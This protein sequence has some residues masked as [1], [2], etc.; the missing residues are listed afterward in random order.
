LFVGRE[1]SGRSDDAA[2]GHVH[3]QIFAKSAS[4]EFVNGAPQAHCADQPK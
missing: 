2:G 4:D 1:K 3:A